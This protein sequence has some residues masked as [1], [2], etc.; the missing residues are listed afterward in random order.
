MPHAHALN[1]SHALAVAVTLASL[2]PLVHG[3]LL[4]LCTEHSDFVAATV[5][6]IQPPGQGR[7][8]YLV[9]PPR[10]TVTDRSSID[11]HNHDDDRHEAKLEY[12]V[13]SIRSVRIAKSARVL[14][15]CADVA[16]QI[17]LFVCEG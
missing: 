8:V 4:A 17:S 9:L 11:S 1:Y 5:S 6:S 15:L 2:L 12:Q 13:R 10:P 14:C 7:A 3:T 16:R